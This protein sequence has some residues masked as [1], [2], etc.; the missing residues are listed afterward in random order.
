MNEIKTLQDGNR[1]RHEGN[2]QWCKTFSTHLKP[3]D[4]WMQTGEFICDK[5]K[6]QMT[7]SKR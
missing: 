4:R 1:V 2:C 3:S 7:E 6:N 5:C